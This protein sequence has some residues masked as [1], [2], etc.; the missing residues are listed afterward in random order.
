MSIRGTREELALALREALTGMDPS[1]V[2]ACSSAVLHVLVS[3]QQPETTRRLDASLNEKDTFFV[4]HESD[5]SFLKEGVTVVLA[6]IPM[7]KPFTAVAALVGLLFR[8]RRKRARIDA[9]QAAVLLCLRDALGGL[10]VTEL[11]AR[12]P[13]ATASTEERVLEVLNGL[14]QVLLADGSRSDFVVETGGYWTASDI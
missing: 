2:E 14:R 5:L 8:Y 7:F 13:L 1:A 4:V 9:E 6:L 10:T 11:V 3:E 12:L